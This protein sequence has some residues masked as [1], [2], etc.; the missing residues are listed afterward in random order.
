MRQAGRPFDVA[1]HLSITK[2]LGKVYVE[3]VTGVFDHDVVIVT[4]T[5]AEDVRSNAVASTA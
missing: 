4:I 1:K 5:D 3:D 2:E